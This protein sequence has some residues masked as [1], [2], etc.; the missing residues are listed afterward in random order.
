MVNDD[1]EQ[2]TA[3][4]AWRRAH[5]L[6]FTEL[7]R[8]LSVDVGRAY[9]WCSGELMPR[10]PS[11]PLIQE[12]TGITPEELFAGSLLWKSGVRM[13][14]QKGPKPAHAVCPNCGFATT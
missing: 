2:V 9:R 14:N 4:E 12:Q 1:D 6:S 5:D 7:G 13:R 10:P 11:W 3:M 8:L